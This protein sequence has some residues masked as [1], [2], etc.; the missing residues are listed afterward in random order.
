M[1]AMIVR[2]VREADPYDGGV[3][4]GEDRG[5]SKPPPYG[6]GEW[7]VR[8]WIISLPPPLRGHLPHQREVRRPLRHAKRDTSPERGGKAAQR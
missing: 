7:G 3:G 8:G 2:T 1:P 4:A 6:G 5:G